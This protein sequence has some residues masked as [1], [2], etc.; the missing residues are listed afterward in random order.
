VLA[1]GGDELE[2]GDAETLEVLRIE[3]GTPRQGAELSEDVLP[4]ETGLVGRAVNLAKGCYTGQEDR[5]AHGVARQREPPPGRAAL[6][7]RRGAAAARRADPRRRGGRRHVTSAC[8]SALAGVIAL[9]YLRRA[10]AEVGTEVVAGGALRECRG[11]PSWRSRS[12]RAASRRRVET[13]GE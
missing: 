9:A 10:H 6:R 5:R 12:G 7:R 2:R 4:A 8:R 11:C 3:A 13:L 1:A